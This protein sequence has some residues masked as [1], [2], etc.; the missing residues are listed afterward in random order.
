MNNKR[1]DE[2]IDTIGNRHREKDRSDKKVERYQE[3]MTNIEEH[4]G[5]LRKQAEREREKDKA[6]ER[7]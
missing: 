1:V 7:D 5:R 3:K 4:L 2:E 6:R